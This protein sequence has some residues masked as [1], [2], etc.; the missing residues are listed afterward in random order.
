[1]TNNLTVGI[2]CYN[3]SST[4]E[5]TLQSI[6]IQT[7]KPHEV[8][9]IDDCS[10]QD[11]KEIIGRYPELNIRYIRLD[12]NSGVGYVRSVIVN[13]TQTKYLTMID[14]DD[15]F[16]HVNVLWFFNNSIE[17]SEFDFLQTVFVREEKDKTQVIPDNQHATCHSKVYNVEFLKTNNINFPSLNA[18][19][20]GMVNR[21]LLK[22]GKALQSSNR[23]YFWTY[24][25]K[26][27]TK[28]EDMMYERFIDYCN[29]FLLQK[30]HVEITEEEVSGIKLELMTL[31][32]NY[33]ATEKIK[34]YEDFVNNNF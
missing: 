24:N 9:I 11:Y 30:E 33:G 19:E 12:E 34:E 3:C 13:E 29:S 10:N 17:E 28:K 1:M 4:L 27:L 31:K 18:Y 25:E 26:G 16:F 32:Q 7:F 6:N 21:I 22:K 23:T 20:E 2:P 8:L 14:A 5:Q 15:F